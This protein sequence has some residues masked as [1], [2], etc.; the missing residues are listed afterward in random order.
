MAATE[1]SLI[2]VNN[3]NGKKITIDTNGNILSTTGTLWSN[4]SIVSQS[5]YESGSTTLYAKLS[6]SLVEARESSN[7]VEITITSNVTVKEGTQVNNANGKKITIDGNDKAYT[8]TT[9][10]NGFNVNGVGTVKFVDMKIAHTKTQASIAIT[11]AAS[12]ILEKVEINATANGWQYGL[13]NIQAKSAAGDTVTLDMDQVYVTMNVVT[14]SGSAHGIVRVDKA[15]TKAVNITVA[16]SNLNTTSASVIKGIFVQDGTSVN[17]TTDVK[18]TTIATKDSA[19][20]YDGSGKAAINKTKCILSVAEGDNVAQVGNTMYTSFAD[21]L[22]TA[23]TSSKDV[24][25]DLLDDLAISEAIVIENSSKK[26]ITIDGNM[27]D[28]TTTAKNA[29]QIKS[30]AAIKNTNIEH[31]AQQSAIVVSAVTTVDITD[32]IMNASTTGTTNLKYGLINLSAKN[33]T[34]TLNLTRVD[35]TVAN[36]AYTES[37]PQHA[38]IRTGNNSEVRTV[39]INLVDCNL[40]ATNAPDRSGILVMDS[41]TAYITLNNSK[42]YTQNSTK[43]APIYAYAVNTSVAPNADRTVSVTDNCEL[44]LGNS[45]AQADV[46][47]N[48]ASD[49]VTVVATGTGAAVMSLEEETGTK[50]L[51]VDVPAELYDALVDWIRQFATKNGWALSL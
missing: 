43:C 33:G 47:K 17:V 18:N 37:K 24:T 9:E 48:I 10:K 40:N 30:A 44:K 51:I 25:I 34:T 46:I 28:I 50:T 19:P 23:K 22:A 27:Y 41:S 7:D 4:V 14:G 6:D 39:Y 49:K 42:I 16:N 1:L 2:S 32:V 35:V 15:T 29:I 31:D 3:T 36:G 21:A 13:I 38:I 11:G 5:K 20:I 26:T 45:T 8:V 12:V